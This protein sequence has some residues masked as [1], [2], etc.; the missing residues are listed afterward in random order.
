[1]TYIHSRASVDDAEANIS[2]ARS[3][4]AQIECAD[5]DCTLY[6]VQP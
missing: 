6:N 2:S 4:R 5:S 3:T 1:M